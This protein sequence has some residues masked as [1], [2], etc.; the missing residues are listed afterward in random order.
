[1]GCF[2]IQR[3]LVAG[4]QRL[5]VLVEYVPFFIL[6]YP[7]PWDRIHIDSRWMQEQLGR[8]SGWSWVGNTPL[9]SWGGQVWPD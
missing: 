6:S 7:H 8:D 2:A 1:M 9:A 4:C 3:S 5:L